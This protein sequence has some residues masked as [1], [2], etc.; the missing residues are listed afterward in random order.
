MGYYFLTSALVLAVMPSFSLASEYNHGDL[1]RD[2]RSTIHRL[3]SDLIGEPLQLEIFND[4]D[5]R[6][7]VQFKEGT[8]DKRINSRNYDEVIQV[9]ED[10][11]VEVIILRNLDSVREMEERDDVLYVEKD[12]KVYLQQ[13]S[14]DNISYGVNLVK[15]MSV[16]DDLVGN[17]KV[18]IIDTGYDLN[19][20]DLPSTS[21]GAE[22]TGTSYGNLNWFEDE[23]NHGTFVAGIVSALGQ[24]DEG[25]IGLIRNGK[26]NLHIARM[27]NENASFVWGSDLLS[28][29][30]DCVENGANIVNI[31]LGG[32]GYSQFQENAF[33]RLHGQENVLIVAA[34][35]NKGNNDYDYPA[36]FDSV[37]SVAAVDEDEKVANFSQKNQAVDIAAPGVNIKSTIPGGYGVMSGTSMAT[38]FVSGVGALVWSHFPDKTASEIRFALSVTAKDLGRP[39]RDEEYGHG[40]IQADKAFQLLNGEITASP[41]LSPVSL[42]CFDSPVN[43]NAGEA[44][45]NCGWFKAQNRC[46]L[47]GHKVEGAED[48]TANEACCTCGGGRIVSTTEIPTGEKSS[49]PSVTLSSGPSF[50]YSTV[51]SFIP[52]QYPTRSWSPSI[53]PSNSLNPSEMPS[54]LPSTSHPTDVPSFGHSEI[55]SLEPSISMLP[56]DMP[57][58]SI[59]P[60]NGPSSKPSRKPSFHPSYS[61]SQ[62]PTKEQSEHPSN[63]P[64]SKPS[65]SPSSLPTSKPF[66]TLIPSL[67]ND[68]CFDSQG[69]YDAGGPYFDCN[70]YSK[71]N[72]CE[73]Y[74]N[75]FQ[76][77]GQTASQACCACG[78]GTINDKEDE[79]K[80]VNVK[81]WHD[82]ISPIFNCKWYKPNN[83]CQ[84]YGNMF[85]NR[86]HTANTACC[87]CKKKLGLI[88]NE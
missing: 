40:L 86:G 9:H 15:A 75:L 47:Y 43:W 63:R 57:S 72:Y 6:F 23:H 66:S 22:I 82:S 19:H 68:M 52:S 18:C 55:P 17:Q 69:W 20:P 30:E 7:V 32:S 56:S 8:M 37:M 74:G 21:T 2:K 58:M 88:Y 87:V 81:N 38:P 76:N 78:G 83:R 12:Q 13:T 49:S 46:Q 36:S 85:E 29:T 65:F 84:I 28:A 24:N 35:G 33:K 45:Y 26:I 54:P 73:L 59:F 1:C 42:P 25:V 10:D 53:I 4:D 5:S 70:F 27:F 39:G 31:S 16:S 60:T 44:R 77:F 71:K 3:N 64:T 11:D 51:P 48:K 62:N 41:T 50:H 34:A 67:S 79:K 14:I 80:C 61:P